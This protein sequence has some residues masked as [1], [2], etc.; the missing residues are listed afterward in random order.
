MKTVLAFLLLLSLNVQAELRSRPA[1][2]AQPVLG[3]ELTNF[4]QV[5]KG[6]YRSRQPYAEHVGELQGMGIKEVLNLRH[7]RADK[8]E[9]GEDKFTLHQVILD[10]GSVTQEQ[11]I[12]AL[13]IIKKR[14]GPILVHC[15][16]GADRAG[17][18]MAAYRVVFNGWSKSEAIDEMANGGYWHKVEKYPNLSAL[19]K[20]MDVEYMRKELGFR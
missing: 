15:H 13:K 1:T 19:I 17:V 14:K 12:S 11:L 8:R 6:V 5:D 3:A 10:A 2:W 20:E 4:Y 16:H 18:T 9:L 7:T